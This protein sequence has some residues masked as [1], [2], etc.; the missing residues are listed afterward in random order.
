MPHLSS[1]L[2]RHPKE[3]YSYLKL[4]DQ[5]IQKKEE[6]FDR[7]LLL[8][9]LLYPMLVHNVSKKVEDPKAFHLGLVSQ[10]AADC[11][12]AVFTPFF[13]LPRR[14]R[15]G[16]VSLLT[17][18]YRFTPLQERLKRRM[19]PPKD[20]FFHLALRFLKLRADLE[21]SLLET[22]SQWQQAAGKETR[23]HHPPTRRRR[24]RGP[25]K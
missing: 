19:R 3:I 22:Y 13:H 18:Q 24:K 23:P 20:P 7:P 8:S 12:D 9:C 15:G 4:V 6:T 17:S 5:E 21:P 25:T 14:M 10:E 2:T 16:M 11:I 1:F